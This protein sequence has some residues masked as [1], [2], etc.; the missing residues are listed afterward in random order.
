MK[1]LPLETLLYPHKPN[2]SQI[3]MLS[4]QACGL[5]IQLLRIYCGYKLVMILYSNTKLL[6]SVKPLQVSQKNNSFIERAIG[7]IWNYG[8][9]PGI[10]GCI[11]LAHMSHLSNDNW[12]INTLNLWI[13]AD[14][15]WSKIHCLA[16]IPTRPCD[17]VPHD[18]TNAIQYCA[19]QN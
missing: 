19:T 8:V 14:V 11:I 4:K 16:S 3:Y 1:F 2:S 7:K 5:T 6:K 10:P 13:S 12:F 9:V 17:L 15:G 18:V